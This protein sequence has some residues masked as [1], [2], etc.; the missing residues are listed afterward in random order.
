MKTTHIPQKIS[1]IA[2]ANILIEEMR[3]IDI[4]LDALGNQARA[5]LD[6]GKDF[7]ITISVKDVSAQEESAQKFLLMKT[8]LLSE[9]RRILIILFDCHSCVGHIEGLK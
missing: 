8:V 3:M 4:A 6:A 1:R 7:Q 9:L 5:L 2:Q